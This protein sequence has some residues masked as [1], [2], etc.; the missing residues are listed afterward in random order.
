MLSRAEPRDAPSPT[1]MPRPSVP[2]LARATVDSE[3]L[4][5]EFRAPRANC[6]PSAATIGS[7]SACPRG[8]LHV[9]R[10]A[11]LN[12]LTSGE[13]FRTTE[14]RVSPRQP[15]LSSSSEPARWALG[16][17]R[18]ALGA[19]RS[20]LGAGRWAQARLAVTSCKAAS[21]ATPAGS[22]SPGACSRKREA[23]SRA[24]GAPMAER[25]SLQPVAR[26]AT[27]VRERDHDDF[28]IVEVNS[29][30]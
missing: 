24:T 18:W 2:K 8:Q 29:T 11:L 7:R 25:P 28:A 27:P 19:A 30:T 10:A 15:W 4:E 3:G 20:P 17:A 22:N 13:T 6:R 5:H 1:M 14:I 26:F 12:C 9:I 23:T 16:A 21:T